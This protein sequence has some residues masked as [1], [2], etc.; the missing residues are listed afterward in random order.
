MT[1]MPV[2]WDVDVVRSYLTP[3]A[4]EKTRE[5]FYDTHICI[6]KIRYRF[7]EGPYGSEDFVTQEE[8]KQAVTDSTVGERNRIFILRGETG[9]GKSQLCQWLEYELEGSDTHVPLHVSR[10]ETR[11]EDIVEIIT[12]PLDR[13]VS[14]KSI[15]GLPEDKVASAMVENLDA[16]AFQ[17]EYEEEI[18][19]LAGEKLKSKLETNIEKYKEAIGDPDE[20]E[21]PDLLTKDQ[22]KELAFEVFN[23]AKGGDTIFPVVLSDLHQQLSDRIGV[24]DFQQQL[25]DVSEHYEDQ[26]LRPVLICEDVTTFNVLKEQLLDEIFELKTGQYDIVLGWTTGFEKEGLDQALTTNQNT[27]SYME[28]RAAGY[29]SMTNEEGQAHFLTDDATV[30]LARKYVNVIREKSSATPEQEIPDDAFD[31]LYPFNPGFIQKAY[32]HLYDAET[33]QE[34][35]TPRLLL[36]RV[37]SECLQSYDPPF[38]SIEENDYIKDDAPPLDMK[39]PD[40]IR[41]LYK[42]FGL[43]TASGRLRIPEDVFDI[44]DVGIPD[45]A[46]RDDGYVMLGRATPGQLDLRLEDGT[47]EPG[48]IITLKAVLSDHPEADVEIESDGDVLGYT[49][50]DGQLAVELPT[51]EESVQYTAKKEGLSASLSFDI[52]TDSLQVTTDPVN[53]TVGQDFTIEVR[54]NGEPVDDVT[55]FEDGEE[56]GTTNSDGTVVHEAPSQSTVTYEAVIGDLSES[57]SVQFQ[58][59]IEF[60]VETS[61]DPDEVNGQQ[62]EFEKWVSVGDNYPSSTT[63]RDGAVSVLQRWHDPTRLANPNSTT[64]GVSG[65]YY[66]R[67]NSVQVSLLGTDERQGLSVE[68]PPGKEHAERYEPMFWAGISDDGD[69]PD[70]TLYDVNY[71]LLRGWADEQVATFRQKMREEIEACLPGEMTIEQLIVFSQFLLLNARR[72]WDEPTRGMVFEDSSKIDEYEHPFSKR[73]DSTDQLREAY[74]NLTKSSSVP[75]DLAEGFF[76]LK[77]NVVDAERLDRAYE[78]VEEN[79]QTYLVRAMQIEYD[80]LA[81]AYQV[82]TSRS[83]NMSYEVKTFLKR[84]RAY[85]QAMNELRAEEHAAYIVESVETIDQWYESDHDVVDLMDLYTRLYEAADEM[86]AG[87]RGDWS[88]WQDA[89]EILEERQD[90]LSFATFRDDIETFRNV[91]TEQGFDLVNTLHEYEK[92]R[93]Q[94]VEWKIYESIAELVEAIDEVEFEGTD[95]FEDQVRELDRLNTY[96]EVRN[97]VLELS[98]GE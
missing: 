90:K 43:P 1:E 31:E 11:P 13:E 70:E 20:D 47:I 18:S 87:D 7:L 96:A 45:Q 80:D 62:V 26:D 42:W 53:P 9:S 79:L 41:Y 3:E 50:S 63:L 59:E 52:G 86:D 82:S 12:E 84:V 39:Y 23:E 89:R 24:G 8:F 83:S 93:E 76:L 81:Q 97:R 46:D 67:G 72:G 29:L 94:R 30:E 91:E 35:R 22:Y 21:I 38:E 2:D 32:D 4:N 61:M 27:F 58:R 44:F 37:I 19:Q 55:L 48:A 71:D 10:S 98:G 74:G 16:Y 17:T 66:A 36:I 77:E 68:L 69:L 64:T 92:S 57:V 33:G 25:R 28:E 73:F 65:I 51:T 78:E 56:I 95:D 40:E 34:R 14:V 75:S 85:A 88:K 15:D 54:L 60:P 49:D 6:D 5:Q